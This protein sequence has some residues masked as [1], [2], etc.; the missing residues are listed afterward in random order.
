MV[1][2]KLNSIF[3][4]HSRVLLLVLAVLIHSSIPGEQNITTKLQMG[5]NLG[6][7]HLEVGVIHGHVGGPE[8]TLLTR[9]AGRY[10]IGTQKQQIAC[11]Q[12]RSNNYGN[13]CNGDK[14]SANILHAGLI[15]LSKIKTVYGGSFHYKNR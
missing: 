14:S 6:I 5:L 12:Q 11:D 7:Q 13:G 2:K 15:S 1:I 10:V 9:L 3:H 8:G 4:K